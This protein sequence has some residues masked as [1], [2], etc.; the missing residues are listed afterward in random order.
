MLAIMQNRA[1]RPLAL[2]KW[3]GKLAVAGDTCFVRNVD[4]RVSGSEN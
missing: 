4:T 1:R 2:G 3:N